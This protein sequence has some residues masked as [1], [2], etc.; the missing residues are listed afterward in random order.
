MFKPSEIAE[1]L[2]ALAVILDHEGHAI[3]L[4]RHWALLTGEDTPSL[5]GDRWKS[6]VHPAE[7][8]VLERLSSGD[9]QAVVRLRAGD[10]KFRWHLFRASDVHQ[11]RLLVGMDAD[12]VIVSKI[13][14]EKTAA[15]FQRTLDHVP[16]MIWRAGSDGFFD[17]A[18]KRWL[19]FCGL[20]LAE[21]VGWG[22]RDGVHPEDREGIEAY[23]RRMLASGSEGTYEARVGNDK[24]GYRWCVSIGTPRRD[25][26]GVVTAWYGAIFD[27]EERKAA[28][29]SL[30]LS[31]AYLA[32]GQE[33]SKIGTFGFELSEERLFWS[34][35][36][37][38]ILEYHPQ[39]RPSLSLLVSRIHED[40]LTGFERFRADLRKSK[41]KIEATFRLSFDDGRI[42]HIRVLGQLASPEGGNYT[43]VIMD[44]TADVRTAERLKQSEVE[45]AHVA[46]VA[47]AGELTASIAHEVNQPLGAL[48]ASGGALLRWIERD[49]PDLEKAKAN[50]RRMVGYAQLASDIIARVRTL[51]EKGGST[52]RELDCGGLLSGS[53][54][55]VEA[56]ARRSKVEVE[57]DMPHDL[58][59]IIGDPVQ[60]QQVIINLM[61]N[62]IQALSHDDFSNRIVRV[63]AC[64]DDD[65]VVISCSDNGPGFSGDGEA[66][67]K[68]FHTTKEHGMGMGLA[69][70]R[71]I[72]EAHHGKIT[73]R[74]NPAGGATF[75]VHLPIISS[76]HE[77]RLSWTK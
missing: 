44:V 25:E 54:S 39:T 21:A 72:V 50:A 71:S 55:Y 27:I 57:I 22:W 45:I 11:G 30:Q 41:P 60:L 46:R 69:I 29:T 66:F 36:T 1:E 77:G 49:E 70:C 63:S 2:P 53:L 59:H 3:Y 47:M 73:A 61:M 35:E 7:V 34:D 75:I 9:D 33:L 15:D 28:E 43:A 37:Y 10:G 24:I 68:P 42:K 51:F 14:R 16:A 52:F 32:K 6:F 38:R 56:L 74:Q 58:P 5:L 8:S 4:N 26:N 17:Y 20:T 12:S 64:V 67:F 48:V 40:D 62:A 76:D 23:W 19:D 13:A 31:E 18:N 65:A